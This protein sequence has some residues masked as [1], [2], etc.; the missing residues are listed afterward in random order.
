MSWT[1]DHLQIDL[2]SVCA[3]RQRER[4]LDYF[5]LPSVGQLKDRLRYTLGLVGAGLRGLWCFA[6]REILQ[7]FHAAR[8]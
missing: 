4:A 2:G 7:P 5:S 3:T 8:G 6:S 1:G